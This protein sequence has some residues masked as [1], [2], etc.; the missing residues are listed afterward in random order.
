MSTKDDL[1]TI[2]RFGFQFLSMLEQQEETHELCFQ[3]LSNEDVQQ[4]IVELAELLKHG[5]EP[6]TLSP[7]ECDELQMILYAV[8]GTFRFPTMDA[9][10]N[11][12]LEALRK[13]KK[14]FKP[15]QKGDTNQMLSDNPITFLPD[16][17][18]ESGSLNNWNEFLKTGEWPKASRSVVIHSATLSVDEMRRLNEIKLNPQTSEFSRQVAERLLDE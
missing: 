2:Q 5:Q 8:F 16:N 12:L 7:S 14:I 11:Q 18:R 17:N 1:N 10:C 6:V 4:R 13:I 3:I 9:K 15:K